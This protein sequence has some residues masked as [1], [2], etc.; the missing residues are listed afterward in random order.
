[1][2]RCYPL[3]TTASAITSSE[4]VCCHFYSSLKK[5]F[6][7]IISVVVRLIRRAKN[8]HYLLKKNLIQNQN[9]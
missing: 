5:F 9:H 1:M 2:T 4:S 7:R 8:T 6:K 3:P